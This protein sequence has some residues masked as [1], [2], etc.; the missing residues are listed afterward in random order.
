MD[1]P[2]EI[3]RVGFFPKEKARKLVGFWAAKPALRDKEILP[4]TEIFYLEKSK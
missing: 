4:L 1:K 2:N 3:I